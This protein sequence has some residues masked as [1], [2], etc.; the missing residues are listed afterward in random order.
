MTPDP[1]R[2]RWLILVLIRLVS[3]AGAVFALILLARAEPVA[4]KLLAGAIILSAL[5]VM[6]FVPAALAKRWRT[7]PE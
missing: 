4:V 1:A 6:A 3:A 2:Q 5:W 7:P